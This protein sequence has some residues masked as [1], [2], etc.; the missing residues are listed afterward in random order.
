MR[1]FVIVLWK[2]RVAGTCFLYN[3]VA[4]VYIV[5]L[6]CGMLTYDFDRF[7]LNERGFKIA[8]LNDYN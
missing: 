1:L 8:H 4:I 5:R 2:Y 6:M 3:I 7:V